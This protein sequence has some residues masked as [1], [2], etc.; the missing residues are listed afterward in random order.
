MFLKIS[1]IATDID[2]YRACVDWSSWALEH[3][4]QYALERKFNHAI[5]FNPLS[6]YAEKNVA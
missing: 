3:E 5:F 4:L 2:S 1:S 6:S